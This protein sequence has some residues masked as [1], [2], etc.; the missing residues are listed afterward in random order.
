MV[1]TDSLISVSL[2]SLTVL[3]N[4]VDLVMVKAVFHGVAGDGTTSGR[5]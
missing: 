4:N 1:L 2:Y 3:V 5:M